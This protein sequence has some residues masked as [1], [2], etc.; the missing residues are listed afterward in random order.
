MILAPPKAW[1]RS[2]LVLVVLATGVA[3]MVMRVVV[4]GLRRKLLTGTAAF[5]TAV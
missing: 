5:L 3:T 2:W 4:L 1:L